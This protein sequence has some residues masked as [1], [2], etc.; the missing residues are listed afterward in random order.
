MQCAREGLFPSEE[1]FQ[2]YERL[3]KFTAEKQDFLEQE[4]RSRRPLDVERERFHAEIDLALPG[5]EGPCDLMPSSPI[6]A[7]KHSNPISPP[8]S[9]LSAPQVRKSPSW[10]KSW[11]NSSLL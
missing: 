4:A 7:V 9:P 8:F 11:A 5:R 10:P 6:R 1:A 2:T 3:S